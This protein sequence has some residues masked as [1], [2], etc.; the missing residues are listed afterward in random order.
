M[1]WRRNGFVLVE[2]LVVLIISSI[3]VVALLGGMVAIVRGLQP[4]RVEVRGETLPIAPTFGG[5]PS[6][7][8]VHEALS[9]Q[10]ASARAIYVFGGKHLSLPAIAPAAQMLPLRA[11]ALPHISDFSPG[12]PMNAKSFYDTYAASLG[13]VE[14]TASP[15]DFSVLIVGE[16]ENTLGVT[17]FVQVRRGEATIPDGAT[18]TAFTTRE[19]KLWHAGADQPLRYAF[20]ERPSHTGQVFVGAV[21]TWMR[22]GIVTSDQEEGPSCVI[23]PDPWIYAGARG[24][25]DDLPAFSRFSYF[26]SN[27]P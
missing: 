8:A 9:S 7:L 25:A 26:L 16:N 10:V 6:A 11:Q 21:H 17:C 1:T 20:A 4:Q 23:F 15:D 22:Y 19:V 24:G 27:S 5:F 2:V 12:L 3:V 14:A 18:S 13:D